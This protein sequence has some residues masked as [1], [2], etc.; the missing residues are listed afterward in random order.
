M[1]GDDVLAHVAGRWTT[2]PATGEPRRPRAWSGTCRSSSHRSG[3]R[4]TCGSRPGSSSRTSSPGSAA[5]RRWSRP[6]L[7]G[8]E[9]TLELHNARRI[10]DPRAT[11]GVI[12]GNPVHDA[13]RAIAAATRRRLRARRAARRRAADHAGLRR[14]RS[15]RCTRP[16]APRRAARRCGRSIGR[17]TSS[18]RPTAATR[19]TRT[20]TRRSRACPRRPRSSGPAARSSAPRS[21]ATGCPTTARTADCSTRAGRRPTCWSG[22]RPRR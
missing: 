10:G 13:V 22:S 9:T 5:D 17:S 16:P 14:A 11:W 4:R 7:A 2:M 19:S 6:G 20:S 1:L 18:S 21:A 8:L 3:S 15:S 12:E